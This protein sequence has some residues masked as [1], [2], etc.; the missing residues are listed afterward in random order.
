MDPEEMARRLAGLVP[1]PGDDQPPSPREHRAAEELL[2]YLA[3]HRLLYAVTEVENPAHCI[4]TAQRI[5]RHLSELLAA[6]PGHRLAG[7]LTA[8]R[9]ACGAFIDTAQRYEPEILR[10]GLNPR[11][12]ASWEFMDALGMMRARFGIH[13]ALVAAWFA[14]EVDDKL[15]RVLPP[16]AG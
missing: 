16:T 9:A 2:A 5:R 15:T 4:K 1:V 7:H 14:L 3:G 10:V 6:R 11:H 13:I 12:F 8:M